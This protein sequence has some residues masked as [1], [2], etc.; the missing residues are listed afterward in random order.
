MKTLFFVALTLVSGFVLL[1]SFN[2]ASANLVLLCLAGITIGLVGTWECC[3]DLIRS[4]KRIE[5]N[6]KCVA[7][8]RGH[9]GDPY[10]H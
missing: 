3:T 7:H 10:I 2:K 4:S 1:S 8:N 6:P 9:G 5:Y